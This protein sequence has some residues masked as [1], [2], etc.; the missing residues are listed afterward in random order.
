MAIPAGVADE[1]K[2]LIAAL[3]TGKKVIDDAKASLA[4]LDRFQYDSLKN[5][6]A[7]DRASASEQVRIRESNTKQQILLQRELDA[8][9]KASAQERVRVAQASI[10]QQIL[11]QKSLADQQKR[12]N[13]IQR[14]FMGRLSTMGAK[15]GMEGAIKQSNEFGKVLAGLAQD[16]LIATGIITAFGVAIKTAFDL[17][18]EGAQI[19]RLRETG[20]RLAQS[21]GLDMD[22]AVS[23]IKAVSLNS[24]TATKAVLQV[25]RTLLLGISSDANEIAKLVEIAALRGRAMGLSTQE[26]FDR[27]TLGIGRLSTRI[28]DDIGIVVDGETAYENFG[29]AI[30]K[31]ADQ[32][33]E[34][35]KR[36]ALKNA[37]IEEGNVLLA[38][39][40]GL[41]LDN[42]QAFE[43]LEI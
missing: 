9:D 12:Y 8:A 4:A 2:I 11:L 33:T 38:K 37:I 23:K 31:T 3:F 25:N 16:A 43:E 29:K 30:G 40:G 34:A 18:K 7:L 42:A 26:A 36:E 20:T 35:Q 21:F 32:L 6:N 19:E 14:T 24:I 13:D 17:G 10:Q 27:I 22:E 5:R 15:G 41:V 1:I 39:A 28:L